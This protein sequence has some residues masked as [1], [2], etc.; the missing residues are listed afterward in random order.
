MKK[1]KNMPFLSK[2]LKREFS[3][4]TGKI[5]GGGDNLNDE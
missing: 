5:M 2:W 4:L 1:E 3:A